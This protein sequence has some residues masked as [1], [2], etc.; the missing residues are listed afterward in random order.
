MSSSHRSLFKTGLLLEFNQ[1][2][3][4][5]P[6]NHSVIPF[7]IYFE[8]VTTLI[9]HGLLSC[10]R[11]SIIALISMRLFVV[12]GSHPEI[13]FVFRACLK[14]APYPPGPGLPLQA[15]SAKITTV[16]NFSCLFIVYF[17]KT[18]PLLGKQRISRFFKVLFR[19]YPELSFE[20]LRTIAQGSKAAVHW[21]NRGISRRQEPYENEGVTILEMEGNKIRFITDFFK[22]TEKF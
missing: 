18:Q 11:A 21:K 4:I 13:S 2:R 6:G 5:H 20:V 14:I 9:L 3:L 7:T 17:P 19:Q 10:F 15:P 22:D 16:S 1:F 12:S 8:S